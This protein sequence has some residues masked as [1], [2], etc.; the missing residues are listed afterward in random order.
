MSQAATL[1]AL[2]VAYTAAVAARDAAHS[3]LLSYISTH[4]TH[5]ASGLLPLEYADIILEYQKAKDAADTAYQNMFI[6][7]N[8]MTAVHKVVNQTA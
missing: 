8:V 2:S 7:A 5:H 4:A 6:S 3:K 1:P